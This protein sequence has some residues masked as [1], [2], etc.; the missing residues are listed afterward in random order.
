MP[1]PRPNIDIP[2]GVEKLEWWGL[3]LHDGEKTWE[4]MYNRLH[5]IRVAR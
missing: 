2:F 1:R 4:Y 3:G 5:T